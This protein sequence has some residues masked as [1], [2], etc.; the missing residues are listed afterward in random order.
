MLAKAMNARMPVQVDGQ[1]SLNSASSKKQ[2][3]TV[4]ATLNLDRDTA[5][6]FLEK[7]NI[8]LAQFENS[9][10]ARYR[11]NLCKPGSTTEE[12]IRSGGVISYEYAHK[13]GTPFMGF[14]VDRCE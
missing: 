5:R 11:P 13:D 2:V 1:V 9:Y 7:N 6:G 4:S 3:V 10:A 8:T 12:F 14:K